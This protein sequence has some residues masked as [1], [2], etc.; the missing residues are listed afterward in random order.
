MI[1]NKNFISTFQDPET[2]L[3]YI[4]EFSDISDEKGKG[5]LLINTKTH[6]RGQRSLKQIKILANKYATDHKLQYRKYNNNINIVTEEEVDFAINAML[7]P[8]VDRFVHNIVDRMDEDEAYVTIDDIDWIFEKHDGYVTCLIEDEDFGWP[9]FTEK[10]RLENS[11]IEFKR[12][13]YLAALSDDRDSAVVQF[14]T[15]NNDYYWELY[16]D[17]NGFN[18]IEIDRDDDYDIIEQKKIQ[19]LSSINKSGEFLDHILSNVH[20][21]GVL[22]FSSGDQCDVEKSGNNYILNDD[23]E[24]GYDDVLEHIEELSH[25]DSQNI[26]LRSFLDETHSNG[27]PIKEI[28]A[29]VYGFDNGFYY[30]SV[31]A[32]DVFISYTYDNKTGDLLIPAPELL[33]C[34]D[35]G[36][37]YSPI[38]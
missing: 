13:L 18:F 17:K 19:K 32:E 24:N 29:W 36:A 5:W 31:D 22:T 38:I 8:K 9:G 16:W 6:I 12:H 4:A 2:N 15:E 3:F 14:D 21:I 37:R 27:L 7:D 20:D 30:N 34:D 11:F 28:R 25:G 33:Y 26:I 10:E 23:P 35:S 1:V